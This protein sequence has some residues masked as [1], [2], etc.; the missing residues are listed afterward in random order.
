MLGGLCRDLLLGEIAVQEVSI[1]KRDSFA[2]AEITCVDK[3][4]DE[5][6]SNRH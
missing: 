2:I 6:L 3:P 5:G 1:L 4:A